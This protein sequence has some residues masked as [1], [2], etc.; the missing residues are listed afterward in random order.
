MSSRIVV[1][2]SPYRRSHGKAPR[3]VGS[4]GF[5]DINDQS[6]DSVQFF[7]GSYGFARKQAVAHFRNVDRF[8]GIVV[9]MP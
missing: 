8:S 4:W 7:F 2:D 6:I 3:G 9:V 5:A 1:D